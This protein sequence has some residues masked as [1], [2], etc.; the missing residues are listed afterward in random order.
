[1]LAAR[2][3][4]TIDLGLPAYRDIAARTATLPQ[5]PA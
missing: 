2:H 5:D 1:V 4:A 3:A